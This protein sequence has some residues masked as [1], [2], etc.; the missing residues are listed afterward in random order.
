M[1]LLTTLHKQEKGILHQVSR[2]HISQSFLLYIDLIAMLSS[3]QIWLKWDSPII[4]LKPP[5]PTL[6][7]YF[8]VTQ[9]AEIWYAN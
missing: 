3:S 5:H 7:R 1:V 4:S 2:T 8:Q 6:E 9:E